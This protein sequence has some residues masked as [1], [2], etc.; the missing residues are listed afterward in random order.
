MRFSNQMISTL[1]QY[2]NVVKTLD[3]GFR[4]DCCSGNSI[5]LL[6]ILCLAC[7]RIDTNIVFFS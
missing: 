6:S 2:P 4:N 3:R 5:W 7:W 1:F